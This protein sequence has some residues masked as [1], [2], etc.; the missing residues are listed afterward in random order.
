METIIT[1]RVVGMVVLQYVYAIAATRIFYQ[2][3][4]TTSRCLLNYLWLS[5]LIFKISEVL[6]SLNSSS[7]Q[8]H[9]FQCLGGEVCLIEKV[10][11]QD[12]KTAIILI[13]CLHSFRCLFSKASFHSMFNT[14]CTAWKNWIGKKEKREGIKSLPNGQSNGFSLCCSA[15]SCSQRWWLVS[16]T[17]FL[18][19]SNN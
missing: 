6:K 11:K 12:F 19:M 5:H 1:K 10:F 18:S 4:H 3:Q 15:S 8:G 9:N 14:I 7:L 16:I 13:A 2:Y 17:S